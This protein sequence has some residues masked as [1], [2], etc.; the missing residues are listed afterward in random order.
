MDADTFYPL[1]PLPST[2]GTLVPASKGIVLD[3]DSQED[4][5]PDL[6]AWLW[7]CC[8]KLAWLFFL[9]LLTIY[10]LQR[11]LADLHWQA[12]YWRAQHQRARRREA[13]VAEQNQLLQGQ[14]RE[15]KRRLFGRKSETSSST[16]PAQGKTPPTDQQRRSRG[17]QHGGKGHGRR[18]QDHL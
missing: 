7:Q 3:P 12:N 11:Q 16:K 9:A 5:Q 15:L 13:E 2:Q 1:V 4:W 8:L 6:A 18:T 17:Q 10:R 14:I